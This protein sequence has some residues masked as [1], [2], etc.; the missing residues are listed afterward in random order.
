[1]FDFSL[2]CEKR[3]RIFPS[4]AKRLRTASVTF[5]SGNETHPTTNVPRRFKVP[6]KKLRQQVSL[7]K[8]EQ[9]NCHRLN[10]STHEA[11]FHPNAGTDKKNRT[12]S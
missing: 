6:H 11:I 5:A 8:T 9:M 4:Y 10:R 2:Q 3:G 7:G 12:E 1:M